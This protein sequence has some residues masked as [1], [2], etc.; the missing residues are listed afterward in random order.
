MNIR[1]Y[2][3]S[4]YTIKA[5]VQLQ[6]EKYKSIYSILPAFSINVVIK[7]LEQYEITLKKKLCQ[8]CTSV[9]MDI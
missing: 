6:L 1:E 4:G 3:K 7:V 8:Y 5:C 9:K 2:L